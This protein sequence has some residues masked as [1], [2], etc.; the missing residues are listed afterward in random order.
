[1]V[2][3][4]TGYI[5][6]DLPSITIDSPFPYKKLALSGGTGSGAALD[7]VVGTGGGVISFDMVDPGLGYSIGDVLSLDQLP[8]NPGVSTLP[9][10]LQLR[11]PR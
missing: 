10:L 8:Y 5:S 4:R 11:I 1:M 6:S 2:N 9:L 3:P 7:V